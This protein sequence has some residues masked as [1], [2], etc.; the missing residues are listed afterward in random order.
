MH[1]NLYAESGQRELPKTSINTRIND[2]KFYVPSQRLIHAVNVALHLNQ[3]LLLTGE[4]GTGKTQLAH[5]L[6]HFFKL[7]KPIVFNAQTTSTAK[8]LFYRY[9]AIGHFQYSQT[10]GAALT[11]DE[12]ERKYINYKGRL[13]QAIRE[14]RRMV[15]LI[16]EI[17][18][19]PRD[20][21]N[22]ILAALEHLR[23]EVPEVDKKY[24]ADRENLPVIIMTSNSEKNLPDAFLRRVVYYH[25]PFP[26]GDTLLKILQSKTD[27]FAEPQLKSVIQFFEL[28][29]NERKIK[30]HKKPATAELLYWTALLKELDFDPMKLGERKQLEEAEK[31]KL[32]ISYSVLAKTKADLKALE[33]F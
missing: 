11:T 32:H 9:D 7:E 29:R 5:H 28:I 6:A 12:I 18:K 31:T 30:L 10:K 4:P 1:F 25:I 21:P 15:V 16:D 22:D 20:L 26:D 24:E 13:G 27:G 19:A 23:F 8:D 3:P 17:D 14:N 2:P 33:K